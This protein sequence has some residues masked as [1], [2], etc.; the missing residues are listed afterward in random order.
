MNQNQ[1][2][3]VGAGLAGLLA[4]A[5][6]RNRVKA[7]IEKQPK[8]PNNHTAVM[9]FRSSAV[10]DATNIP[11]RKVQVAW[12]IQRESGRNDLYI[13]MRYSANCTAKYD[14]TR[15][16][17]RFL[18]G[19]TIDERYISPP[20]LPSLLAERVMA[21]IDFHS[22]VDIHPHALCQEG[23]IISTIPMPILA[24]TLGY[25]GFKKSKFAYQPGTTCS[26]LV[27]NLD[28]YA[29]LYLPFSEAFQRI[30]ITGDKIAAESYCF[31]GDGS[32]EQ[33]LRSHLANYIGILPVFK[34]SISTRRS[35]YAKIV[36]IDENERR[37][38]IRWATREHGVYS[39]GRF[40][41]WRPGLL[42][43]DVVQDVRHITAML[44]GGGHDLIHSYSKEA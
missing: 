38:F 32:L 34:N 10:A 42:L 27:E 33:Y 7:I 20:N 17:A 26:V 5:M 39:L 2:I 29:T 21:D 24:K 12:A 13:A 22:P 1:A 14:P 36:S 28:C 41:T 15:S 44:D 18:P 43:D 8:L 19:L 31:S 30:S 4:G 9:R 23:P 40:A 11:F 3:I 25:E 6:M 37:H 35:Q 16:I